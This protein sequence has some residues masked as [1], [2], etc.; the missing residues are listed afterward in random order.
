MELLA[1]HVE[2]ALLRVVDD[3]RPP[4]RG[5]LDDISGQERVAPLAIDREDHA[6]HVAAEHQPQLRRRADHER[7]VGQRV[8]ADRRQRHRR[9]PRRDDRPAGGHVVGGRSRGRRDD[10]PVGAIRRDELVVDPRLDL[11]EAR[12]RALVQHRIVEREPRHRLGAR[13]PELHREPHALARWQ[14]ARDRRR[15]RA[16]R[17]AR[18]EP[19]QEAQRSEIDP[20]DRPP[21]IGDQPGRAQH[22]AVAA[23]CSSSG[24][25]SAPGGASW[26]SVVRTGTCPCS[27]S[28]GTSCSTSAPASALSGLRMKPTRDTPPTYHGHVTLN[29]GTGHALALNPWGMSLDRP[30]ASL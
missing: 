13:P 5:H 25:I 4:G 6:T 20:E 29:V 1:H 17:L 14:L 11:H 24:T 18:R 12:H 21:L 28:Q 2:E 10:Q 27:S 15:E 16:L 26:S 22:R 9:H 7:P 30:F 19:G 3:H 8:R 23:Q